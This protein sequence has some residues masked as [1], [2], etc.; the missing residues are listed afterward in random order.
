MWLN[1]IWVNLLNIQIRSVWISEKGANAWKC[2][3]ITQKLII[4]KAIS[5]SKSPELLA[6]NLGIAGFKFSSKWF[7]GFIGR[8]D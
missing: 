6:N 2:C 5:L 8:Y 4:N 1:S 3:Y 7:D